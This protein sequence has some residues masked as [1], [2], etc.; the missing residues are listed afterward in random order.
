M[1]GSKQQCTMPGD[2]DGEAI[3]AEAA[4]GLRGST[5]CLVRSG[6]AMWSVAA[7]RASSPLHQQEVLPSS[8]E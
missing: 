5:L 1:L 7:G 2:K 6:E 4:A 8:H 3:G